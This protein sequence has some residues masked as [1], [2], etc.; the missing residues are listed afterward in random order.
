MHIPEHTHRQRSHRVLRNFGNKVSSI[1]P[2]DT[3]LNQTRS[4][5]ELPL[6]NLQVMIIIEYILSELLLRSERSERLCRRR[7]PA[8][9]PSS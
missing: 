5:N 6:A 3:S 4:V 8:S 9:K 1:I 7:G 2:D